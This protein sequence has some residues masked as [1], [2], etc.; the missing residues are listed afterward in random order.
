MTSLSAA[1][2]LLLWL[3]TQAPQAPKAP[4]PPPRASL[5]VRHIPLAQVF[6]GREIILE[7]TVTPASR[8]GALIA[9]HRTAGEAAF[10]ETAFTLTTEGDYAAHIPVPPEQ[11]APVEYY[12]TARDTEGKESVRFA[13]AEHPH[14]VLIQVKDGV[15][16]SEALLA[17]YDHRRSRVSLF[18]EY[19]DFG[20]T[21]AGTVRYLD[22]Y[23]RLEA[24]Y[25]H[26]L[27]TEVAGVRLNSI[28]IGVGHLRARVPPIQLPVPAD[29]P[30]LEGPPRTVRTGL[31]YGFSELDVGLSSRFGFTTKVM[32]GGNAEG[33]SAGLGGQLRIGP[34]RGS[35]VELGV[36][37]TS[38]LGTTGTVRLA[39]D[40]VTRVP[41]S[42]ALQVTDFPDGPAGVRLLYSAD[43][44]LSPALTLGAMVG[45]QA[46][47]SIS[48]GPTLGLASS[49]AW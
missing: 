43:F 44:E 17:S 9:H 47:I 12:L 32:L 33:F 21:R 23:Y 39:W 46:R 36:E 27:L 18:A 15:L 20:S 31:D 35:H 1:T 16:E 48:G 10:R 14:T 38:G 42:A 26:R 22:R 13:S 30:P 19:V 3:T 40:T 41:M 4:A 37:T 34:A 25:L 5:E 7:A 29:W 11:H 49:Y 2:A 6:S 45:Y 28:R 8:L 24:D